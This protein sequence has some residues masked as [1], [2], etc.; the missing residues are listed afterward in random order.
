MGPG[1]KDW[2]QRARKSVKWA[3]LERGGLIVIGQG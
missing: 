1:V 3:G 2:G